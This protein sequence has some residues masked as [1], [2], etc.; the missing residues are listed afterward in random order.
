M[1][2]M[3]RRLRMGDEKHDV[4]NGNDAGGEG[5][6]DASRRYREGLEKSVQKGDA[7]ELGKKAREALEGAEGAELERAEEEGKRGAVP[8]T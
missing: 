4:G 1:I 8:G 7:E 3:N 6:Y 5:N 2:A